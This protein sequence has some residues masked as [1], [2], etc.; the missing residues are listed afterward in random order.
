MESSSKRG[1]R[2]VLVH[3]LISGAIV[4]GTMLIGFALADGRA[5]QV[6][7]SQAFG[8][9]IMLVALSIIF[10]GVKRYRD[11]ELGGVIRF[12]PAL[13][14]GA[15][16]S[17]VAGLV[18]VAGWEAHLAATDYAFIEEDTASVIEA[19]RQEGATA[20]EL[21]A[22]EAEMQ[23]MRERYALPLFRVPITFLEIFP[24]GLLISLISA[25]VLRNPRVRPATT[26][27]GELGAA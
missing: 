17:A 19:S 11:D 12:W 1:V 18:Y 3:G 5:G 2:I 26:G 10:F 14:V 22:V 16:I 4:I 6:A 20:E 21:A 9:L 27:C 15:A 13:G 24:V 8:Y 23:V 7:T 25:A